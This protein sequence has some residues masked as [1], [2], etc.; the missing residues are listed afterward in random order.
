MATSHALTGSVKAGSR[1]AST[2]VSAVEA[3]HTILQSVARELAGLPRGKDQIVRIV[4]Y[5]S[6][7]SGQAPSADCKA[8][9]PT[10][11][12]CNVY[13][14]ADLTRPVTDFGCSTSGPASPDRYWCPRDRKTALTGP[15]GPPD[16][17]G[18]YI[19]VTHQR[20]AGVV[21]NDTTL[22]DYSVNRLEPSKR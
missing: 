3:D 1:T 13:T 11:G 21:G 12:A 19:E 7:A 9:V 17:I 20:V 5:R 10:A 14:A 18:I 2:A 15:G 4:I 6:T 22:S 16:Y 8:G